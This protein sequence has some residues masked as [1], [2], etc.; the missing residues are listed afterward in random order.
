MSIDN[1]IVI[2]T[3]RLMEWEKAK[4]SLKAI[5]NTYWENEVK[6]YKELNTKINNFIKDLDENHLG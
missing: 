4:G 6:E 1:S 5:L 3:I 2:K